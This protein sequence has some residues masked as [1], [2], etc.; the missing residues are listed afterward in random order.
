MYHWNTEP[1]VG[2]CMIWNREVQDHGNSLLWN[3]GEKGVL[4]GSIKHG[5]EY[6]VVSRLRRKI[7]TIIEQCCVVSEKKTKC[8]RSFTGHWLLIWGWI[9]TEITWTGPWRIEF[10]QFFLLVFSANWRGKLFLPVLD[11]GWN[12][13]R[14]W[15]IRQ[16]DQLQNFP[17]G[18]G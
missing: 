13:E 3:P 15:V 12:C 18:G 7:S 16:T 17:A 2:V 8:F 6:W 4:S 1:C 11:S 5:R 14:S 10:K 9:P